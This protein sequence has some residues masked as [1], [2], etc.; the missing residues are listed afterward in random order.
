MYAPLIILF[1]AA[2]VIM[3][4]GLLIKANIISFFVVEIVIMV[5]IAIGTIINFCL[6][7]FAKGDRKRE[8]FWALFGLLALVLGL[9]EFAQ[10]FI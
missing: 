10:H 2:I 5:I 7:L 4:E 9:L 6:W 3:V 1:G 8:G